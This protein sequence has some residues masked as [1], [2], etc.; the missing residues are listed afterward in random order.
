MPEAIPL[1]AEIVGIFAGATSIGTGIYGAL[2]KPGTP[3]PAGPDPKALADTANK[4]RTTQ[5]ASLSQAFPGIQAATGGSLS[6]E[7]WIELS[8][9]ISGK[10]G[11]PG[12]GASGQDLLQKLLGGGSGS[13]VSVGGGSTGGGTGS[14]GLTPGGTYG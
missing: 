4:T 6:P 1:I 12:I 11:E 13:T 10:A 9:L 5:E 14:A 2:N 8:K 3:T 7:A